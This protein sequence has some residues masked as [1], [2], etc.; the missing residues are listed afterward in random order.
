[1]D[2]IGLLTSYGDKWLGDAS[3]AP[4]LTELNRRKAVIYTHPTTA[5]CCAPAW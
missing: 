3:F 5:A 4:V 1:M 2:G